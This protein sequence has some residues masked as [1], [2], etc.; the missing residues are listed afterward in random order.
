MQTDFARLTAA[1]D[2]VR[3]PDYDPHSINTGMKRGYRHD[4]RRRTAA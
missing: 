4:A 2:R 3:R 1:G